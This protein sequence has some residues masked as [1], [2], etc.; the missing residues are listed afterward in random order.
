MLGA[1]G[2]SVMGYTCAFPITSLAT[3]ANLLAGRHGPPPVII[4]GFNHSGRLRDDVAKASS[5]VAISIDLKP[6]AT[7]GIH[8]CLDVCDVLD[9]T[10]WEEAY[11]NP[12]CMFS[13]LSDT[14]CMTHKL[15]DGRF[16]WGVAKVAAC[17]CAPAAK[18][19]VEQPRS[20]AEEAIGIA[21]SQSVDPR[22]YDDKVKK[23]MRFW[24]LGGS[25]VQTPVQAKP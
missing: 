22:D 17:I 10:E 4:V 1:T 2:Y 12:P 20:H 11:F 7:Q 23:T 9:M 14:S 5:K 8:A 3:L 18:V 25:A 24:V 6:C 21:A 19:F 16:W 15:R 13:S